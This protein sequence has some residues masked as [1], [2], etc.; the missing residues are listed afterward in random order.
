MVESLINGGERMRE[1]KIWKEWEDQD[2]TLTQDI[3]HLG[4]LLIVCDTGIV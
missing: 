2:P 4:L 3:L 1:E